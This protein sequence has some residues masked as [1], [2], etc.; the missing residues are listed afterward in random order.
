MRLQLILFVFGCFSFVLYGQDSTKKIKLEPIEISLITNYYEQTGN[1]SPVT[2]GRGT[3]TLNNIAPSLYV[4]IPVDSIQSWDVN[5]GVDFYSSASSDNIDNPYLQSNHISGASADD[6]RQY[7]S[8]SYSRKN[9]SK[10]SKIKY[11]VGASSEYDVTSLSTSI[12]FELS[13]IHI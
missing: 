8:L 2:G 9:L 6:I 13:L 7:Y 12:G 10:H 11:Q 1:N 5:A 4:H 3:E